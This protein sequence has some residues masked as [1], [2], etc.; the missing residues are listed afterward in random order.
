MLT[1][2]VLGP[3]AQGKYSVGYPTPGT[4]GYTVVCDGCSADAA[5]EEAARRNRQ[6]QATAR[7]IEAERKACGLRKERG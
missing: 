6:Q 5:E 4:T 1:H 3:D 7:A 2:K